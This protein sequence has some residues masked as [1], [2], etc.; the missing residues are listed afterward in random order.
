MTFCK[1]RLKTFVHTTSS[2]MKTSNSTYAVFY[3]KYCNDFIRPKQKKTLLTPKN[4]FK[5]LKI[6]LNLAIKFLLVR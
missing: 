3:K 1:G 6:H 5:F 2:Y 4:C